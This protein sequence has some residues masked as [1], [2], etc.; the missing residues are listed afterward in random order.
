MKWLTVF[1]LP[2]SPGKSKF[3]PL[4]GL[5]VSVVKKNKEYTRETQ[6]IHRKSKTAA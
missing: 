2:P 1:D 5:C 4:S 6:K 3:Y